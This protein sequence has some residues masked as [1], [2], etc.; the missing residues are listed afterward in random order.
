MLGQREGVGLGKG[1]GVSES[2]LGEGLSGTWLGERVSPEN[3]VFELQRLPV[4]QH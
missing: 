3:T 1:A 2:I 4:Q